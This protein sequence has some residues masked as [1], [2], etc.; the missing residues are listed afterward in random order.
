MQEFGSKLY[1]GHDTA[2]HGHKP[3][4][5]CRLLRS[6]AVSPLFRWGERMSMDTSG[7]QI[8]KFKP[9]RQ[10]NKYFQLRLTESELSAI[11]EKSADYKSVSHYIRSAVAEYSN[12]DAKERLNSLIQLGEFYNKWSAELGHLGGNLN[13]YMKRANELAVAGL[14]SEACMER[15]S[16]VVNDTKGTLNEMKRELYDVTQRGVK[17]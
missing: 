15:L 12:V 14:L 7:G 1:F 4:V 6:G 3:E 16:A 5:T 9:M 17:G 8:Q 10:R 2:S 13:Q 11:R